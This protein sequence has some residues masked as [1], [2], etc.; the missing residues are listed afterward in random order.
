MSFLDVNAP[1]GFI[2]VC[3][4]KGYDRTPDQVKP[5]RAVG[6]PIKGFER[7]APRLWLEKGWVEL[8]EEA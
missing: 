8:Q 1:K 4:Q 5:E 6:Q 3:T 7:E 2:F